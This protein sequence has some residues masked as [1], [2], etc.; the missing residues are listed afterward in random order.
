[1]AG[2]R[3]F[4]SYKNLEIVRSNR[5]AVVV[6]FERIIATP[7]RNLF[8]KQYLSLSSPLSAGIRAVWNYFYN[9]CAKSH[10]MPVARG[11]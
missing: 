11:S 10:F 9:Y 2:I 3:R 4:S 1:M 8:A 6:V 5:L 7:L